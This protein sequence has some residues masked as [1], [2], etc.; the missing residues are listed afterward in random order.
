MKCLATEEEVFESTCGEIQVLEHPSYRLE[1]VAQGQDDVRQMT[2]DEMRA[3]L[4]WYTDTENPDS[5]I[6]WKHKWGT[7]ALAAGT[8]GAKFFGEPDFATGVTKI[9]N[10]ASAV[11]TYYNL[12]GQ[13]VINPTKGVFI[14]NG[15]KVIVK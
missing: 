13:Q 5:K 1:W 9:V 3:R 7:R 2:E 12:N 10:S 11:E 4:Y 15:K 14:K 6:L 8:S